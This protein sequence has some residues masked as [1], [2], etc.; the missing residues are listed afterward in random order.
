VV[1]LAEAI[2]DSVATIWPDGLPQDEVDLTAQHAAVAK[3][4][5]TEEEVNPNNVSDKTHFKRGDLVQGF[6]DA[7][8]IIERTYRT[9]TVHQSYMEPHSSVADPDAVKG[10][11][12]VYTSTQG[13]FI[14]RNEIARML[15]LP[16]SRVRI[17]PMTVGGGF[18]AKYGIIDP[19]AAAVAM[20]LDRPIKLVLTRS[21]DF[22][23]TTPSPASIIELKTGA[24][25]DGTLTALEARVF[26]DNGI[27][28]FAL[29]GIAAMLLG[30][31]YKCAN[32]EITC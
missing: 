22:L 10:S 17:V 26:L 18:G 7:D 13:Q 15:S 2:T 6:Q 24:K 14:V 8:V 23:T 21:E 12:T 32:M 30:G 31:Y 11:V 27:F 28:K 29:G 9:G 16:K 4:E 19:L 1:G 3:E 20:T 25:K 5:E